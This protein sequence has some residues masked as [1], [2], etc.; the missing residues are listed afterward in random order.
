[1]VTLSDSGGMLYRAEG[2]RRDHIQRLH[3]L[4]E[5]ERGRLD[6][7]A[8]ELGASHHPDTRPWQVECDIALPCAVQN[9]LDDDDARHLL[10]SGCRLVAEG[11]NMP[12]TPRAVD[13]LLADNDVMFAPGKAVNAGGVA[14]SGLERS[15]NA[16][17]LVWSKEEVDRRLVEIMKT[18]HQ[19]CVE[20]GGHDGTVNYRRGA[21]I[22]G[23]VRLA[24][25]M[26][27]QGVL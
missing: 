23:F 1:V 21:N 13:R 11:A 12:C 4:K 6:S 26:L 22:A 16:Q 19:R 25:A 27:A 8:R 15:Q 3:Q 24:D 5:T 14:V 18:I 9:E 17:H 10:D 20:H 2:F 7:V